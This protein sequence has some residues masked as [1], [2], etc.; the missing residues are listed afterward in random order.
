MNGYLAS[1]TGREHNDNN[2]APNIFL[3]R[4]VLKQFIRAI[5]SRN[6]DSELLSE[7]ITFEYFAGLNI[8]DPLRYEQATDITEEVNTQKVG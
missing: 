4:N 3:N 1:I 5:L 6:T 8:S 7:L 2:V